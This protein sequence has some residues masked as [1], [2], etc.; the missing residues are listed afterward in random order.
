MIIF[1]QLKFNDSQ[2]IIQPT[3]TDLPDNIKQWFSRQLEIG[4]IL[5]YFMTEVDG[6]LQMLS[7]R[8][9][10]LALLTTQY[11]SGEV[12]TGLYPRLYE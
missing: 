12:G 6:Q 10:D 3:V 7:C 1:R 8:L 9:V 2:S 11:K 4:G 5:F